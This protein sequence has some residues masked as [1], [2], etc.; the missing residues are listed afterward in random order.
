M[1]H[2]IMLGLSLSLAIG[3]STIAWTAPGAL[4]GKIIGPGS[5]GLPGATVRVSTED[6]ARSETVISGEGGEFAVRDLEPG[7][8]R[9]EGS[10]HGFHPASADRVVVLPDRPARISLSLASATFHDTVSVRSASPHDTMESTDLRESAARDLGEALARMPGV[11]KVRK[12]GIAND[13]VIRGFREDDITVLLDGA[14]VA[15]ACPNR[16]DP[17]AFH[18]DFAEVDRVELVTGSGRM[19]SQGSMGGTVNIVTKKPQ[20]GLH[21]D[22]SMIAG[23]YDMLNPSGTVSYGTGRLSVLAGF[24]HRQSAPFEDG[25][26]RK[27]TEIANYSDAV[28]GADAYGVTGA[29]TRLYFEPADDHELTLSYARQEADDVLYPT[30]TMDAVFDN[31]DRLVLGYRHVRSSG[32]LRELRATAYSTRVDHWMTDG[33]RSTAVSAP[34]S[35]GMGTSATTEVVGLSA[36]ADISSLTVGVEAYTR[37]WNTWTE[38]AGMGYSRQ[39]S[40]PDVDV[41]VIGLSLRW[42]GDV[43]RHGSLE[44]GGRVDRISTAADS[45]KANTALYAAYHGT[46]ETSRSDTTPSMSIRY[47]HRAS[48]AVTL[49]AGLSR[50]TRAPDARERYFG[51]K[52][53][54]G[55]WV[56]NP[57][58]DPPIANRAELGLQ[59]SVGAGMITATTWIDQVDGFI[60]LYRQDR[61]AMVPGVMNTMA[62]SYTNVDAR[63][64]GAAL[65]GTAALSSRL[66]VSGNLSYV[67]GTKDTDPSRNLLSENLAEMPPLTARL[68]LRWQSPR[69]F[70]EIEG[71]GA[72]SQ[73]RVDTDLSEI[74]TGGYGIIHLKAG[75]T[76][77][78]LR[79]QLI[80]GNVLDET[81]R[82]HFSYIRNPFRSGA[83]INEPGRNLTVTLGWRM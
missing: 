83:M 27:F 55:D 79:L 71:V 77:N 39:F 70:G 68:A 31:T 30:L 58:I 76:W 15:G 75:A 67:R 12:G 69:W 41:D 54:G 6:G 81:Y 32:V 4:I 44:I 3:T 22:I 42:T 26:G 40:I 64:W 43:G 1:Q 23:S 50:T 63:L 33:F 14:R 13:V 65:E 10:L 8:Y 5:A 20:T 47:V 80:L 19:A 21:A 48:E 11:W 51:L 62:Q 78:S 16:M 53:M 37:N 59:W 9:V 36:D 28:D 46:V 74:A 24:S 52:R 18:L 66:F 25:S 57:E 45:S 73:D 72:S 35:W 2:R 34:R 56:G 60:T 17:P 29:W 61:I 82:D 49:N 7:T 38:M